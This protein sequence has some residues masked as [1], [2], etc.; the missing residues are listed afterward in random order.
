MFEGILQYHK[1]CLVYH[2]EKNTILIYFNLHSLFRHTVLSKILKKSYA[3]TK[4]VII[5]F[6]TPGNLCDEEDG[7]THHLF[8]DALDI[9]IQQM[10]VVEDAEETEA[11]DDEVFLNVETS[12]ITPPQSSSLSHHHEHSEDDGRHTWL[13]EARSLCGDDLESLA[14]EAAEDF[15][16]TPRL[17][18]LDNVSHETSVLFGDPLDDDI[19]CQQKSNIDTDMAHK[20][21]VEGDHP[22][23]EPENNNLIIPADRETAISTQSSCTSPRN[24]QDDFHEK[25][26]VDERMSAIISK[27]VKEDDY[28]FQASVAMS[29]AIEQEGLGNFE[30]A[31][32]MYKF[33]IGLLLCG[34]Q[35]DTDTDRRDAVRR[36]TAQY[37]LRA[38]TLYKTSISRSTTNAGTNSDEKPENTNSNKNMSLD[39]KWRFRLSDVK[40]IGL[41]DKVMLVQRVFSQDD[42][43]F[44]MKV[45]HKL[46]AE[47]KR[48]QSNNNNKNSKNNN[49][50]NR[51]LYNS[52][53]MCSLVNCVET[54]TGVYLLLEH[55]H[56]GRLWDF[57]GLKM[58]TSFQRHSSSFAL[59]DTTHH[60][61]NNSA[62]H[63]HS[64]TQ[65]E[66]IDIVDIP[67]STY[68]RQGSDALASRSR[69][70]S[71]GGSIACK[72]KRSPSKSLAPDENCVRV[73]AAQ[74][75]SAL[76]DLHNKGVLCRYKVIIDS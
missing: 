50:S 67:A 64:D 61:L 19:I 56:G 18:E 7:P 76:M 4:N 10:T 70:S 34:V 46:G 26:Q 14:S 62:A 20:L 48:N 52:Q 72:I 59:N 25:I 27:T 36:K 53:F 65:V 75:A 58:F 71:I 31:F 51:N 29:N 44:V 9:S 2:I 30:A 54:K 42:E 3:T 22:V 68:V 17:S 16:I 1:L 43:V 11:P 33:G 13:R 60:S 35:T 21:T 55:V 23:T 74:I 6:L 41:I 5:L 40:V 63:Q 57:L 24:E 12:T 28:V 39:G 38:E 37:L 32:D 66:N 8:N 73:W 69:G 47:Y 15:P 49:K 45:L